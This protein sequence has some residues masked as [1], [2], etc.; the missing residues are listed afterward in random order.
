MTQ[1]VFTDVNENADSGTDLANMLDSFS[2]SIRTGH[3]GE[4]T[5]PYALAGFEWIKLPNALNPS[6][7]PWQ[8]MKYDGVNNIVLYTL[9]PVSHSVLYGGNNERAG[10]T[11]A[12]TDAIKDIF[13]MYRD[14]NTPSSQSAIF[15]QLN[16]NNILKTF[17]RIKSVSTGVANNAE[18]AELHFEIIKAGVLSLA[19]KF[20][21]TG[22]LQ[23]S[24]LAGIGHRKAV[25]SPQGELKAR[26][27]NHAPGIAYYK[28]ET[29]IKGSANYVALNDFTSDALDF[30]NDLPNLKLIGKDYGATIAALDFGYNP[31]AAQALDDNDEIAISA[32][33][34]QIC[35]ITSAAANIS[36]SNLPFG[37][38]PADFFNGMS[39]TVICVDENMTITLPVNDVD[40]GYVGNGPITFRKGVMVEFIYNLTLKRF[41]AKSN[42]F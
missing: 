34:I 1:A 26:D 27:I 21:N 6:E 9:D 20:L 13:E 35:E 17:S 3:S 15:T 7:G 22:A 33:K 2:E 36:I 37:N 39:I 42:N 8:I 11:V 4:D 23:I 12:R 32:K 40:Y 25:V 28:D 16:D 41:L 31:N 24:N 38:D 19:A 10:Y 14:I 18:T 29:I 5:P 30:N